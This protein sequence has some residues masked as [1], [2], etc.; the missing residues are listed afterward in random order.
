MG[1]SYMMKKKLT[2]SAAES[3]ERRS[4]CKK[5][6][7][8]ANLEKKDADNYASYGEAQASAKNER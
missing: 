2:C 6:R 4:P 1:Q 5:L 3:Q 7:E 8:D